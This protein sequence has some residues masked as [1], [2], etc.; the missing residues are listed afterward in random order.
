MQ[1]SQGANAPLPSGMLDIAVTFDAR[2]SG[3]D[4]DISAYLLDASGKVR[5]DTDMIF[6]NQPASPEGAV[7]LDPASGRFAVDLARL[8]PA[9]ERIAICVVVDGGSAGSL[10][11]ITLAVGGGP[12]FRHEVAGTA[13]AAIIVADLY[14]RQGQWKLRA[15]GQGFAGGLAPLARSFGI[16]VADEPAAVPAPPIASPAPPK[17]D[18]H[19][20]KVEQRL[21]TLEK[22]DKKLVSLA[23]AAG[24][25]LAKQ[26]GA[27]RPAR[28]WLI[29]D[30][31]GSMRGLFKSGAVDR[32]AQRALAYGLNLD[33]D[34]E[35]GVILFDHRATMFG[36]V[37]AGNY[38][39]FAQDIQQRKDVWGTTDYGKAMQM[40]RET[41]ARESDFGRTP[42]YVI[43]VTDGG[44]ENRKLAEEQIKSASS[45][46]I[47][48]KFMAIGPMPA[49]VKSGSRKL[50]RG[51]DFLAYLDDM[52]GRVVD[53]ADFFAVEDPDGPSDVEFFD[54]MST[55]Y[56]GWLDAAAKAGVL[57]R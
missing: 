2:P 33:D 25:S 11:A 21:V 14:L 38:R 29:L 6:Y 46:A 26:K 52:P 8:P 56:G 22:Q 51:F 17:V 55:E 47:F 34:G 10:R 54:L 3:L 7:R 9:I 35:I 20:A 43:F 42:V 31:S 28:V 57:K 13:E 44:T 50:P 45:E 5:G 15:V 49:G 36:N 24:L 18:L 41:A 32:L 16:D 37:N 12:S 1:L 27:D 39:T 53:N 40:L 48:W 4:V 23:K 30:V 19:K